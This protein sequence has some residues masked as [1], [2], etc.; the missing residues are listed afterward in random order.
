MRKLV[1]HTVCVLA[2]A[3]GVPAGAATF[4]LGDIV[5]STATISTIANT[6]PTPNEGV[7]YGD[8]GLVFVPAVT[9]QGCGDVMVA[10][11]CGP[12]DGVWP[13]ASQGP[14]VPLASPGF[15]APAGSIVPLASPGFLAPPGSDVP[16]SS[17][18]FLAPTGL[19]IPI[20]APG[21]LPGDQDTPQPMP[22]PMSFLLVGAGLAGLHAARRRRGAGR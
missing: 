22:E 13:R 14:G 1:P 5:T 16:L 18:G 4:T 9:E 11:Y 17:P 3:I 2:L 12:V 15:L 20:A 21:F 19:D 8:D 10:G 7:S 6:E